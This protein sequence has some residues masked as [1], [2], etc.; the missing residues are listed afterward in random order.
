MV[1]KVWSKIKRKYKQSNTLSLLKKINVAFVAK[2]VYIFLRYLFTRE[3]FPKLFFAEETKTNFKI[4][5]KIFGVTL[6]MKFSFTFLP[7]E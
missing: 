5:K 4:Q 6:L 1:S 2:I 3:I 7:N